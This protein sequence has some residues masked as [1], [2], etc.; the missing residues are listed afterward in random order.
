MQQSPSCECREWSKWVHSR[1]YLGLDVGVFDI[2]SKTLRR[3]QFSN[4]KVSLVL[5]HPSVLDYSCIFDH[6]LRFDLSS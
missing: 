4:G 5:N 6:P 2:L 3:F 1:F